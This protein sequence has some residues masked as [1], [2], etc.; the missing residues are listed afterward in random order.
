MFIV[1]YYEYQLFPKEYE[2][3]HEQQIPNG[4]DLI[5]RKLLLLLSLK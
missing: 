1:P 5:L 2:S 4:K 3:L